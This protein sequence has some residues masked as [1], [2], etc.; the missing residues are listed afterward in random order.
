MS[1]S[2]S[3]ASP[4]CCLRAQ[5]RLVLLGLGHAPIPQRRA[6]A[7]SGG[8]GEETPAQAGRRHPEDRD[9]RDYVFRHIHPNGRIIGKPGRRQRQTYEQLGIASL[10]KPSEVIV[11]HDVVEPGK[12]RRPVAAQE[13]AQDDEETPTATSMPEQQWDQISEATEAIASIE[14]LRPENVMVDKTERQRLEKRLL[15]GYS[16]T[17][18]ER[19]LVLS[20]KQTGQTESAP[21]GNDTGGILH[22]TAWKPGHTALETRVGRIS[23]EKRRRSK[24][25]PS[26]VKQILRLAWQLSTESEAQEIGEQELYLSLLFDIN[27]NNAPVKDSLV[28]SPLLTRSSNIQPYRQDK[29]VR[30]TARKSDAAEIA[31]RLERGLARV[32]RDVLDLNVFTPLLGQAGWPATLD[33]L[34]T[35]SDIRHVS[36][37][38]KSVIE[39]DGQGTLTIYSVAETAA[40][41]MH[42]KRLLLALLDL[43]SPTLQSSLRPPDHRQREASSETYYNAVNMARWT[44]YPLINAHRRHQSRARYRAV[45]PMPKLGQSESL[46]SSGIDAVPASSRAHPKKHDLLRIPFLVGKKMADMPSFRHLAEKG[47]ERSHGADW[48]LGASPPSWKARFGVL[49]HA[50]S[51]TDPVTSPQKLVKATSTSPFGSALF[52]EQTTGLVPLL[53][54]FAPVQMVR[55]NSPSLH[56]VVVS[57]QRGS[58]DPPRRL[59]AHLTPSPFSKLG[60]EVM[61]TLPRVTMDFE[62]IDGA[63]SDRASK[64]FSRL[65][66]IH[67]TLDRQELDAAVPHLAGDLSFVR[68]QTV[69]LKEDAWQRNGRVWEVVQ[70]VQSCLA[71]AASGLPADFNVGVDLPPFMLGSAVK[72]QQEASGADVVDGMTVPYFISHYE[73]VTSVDY[74]PLRDAAQLASADAKVKRVVEHWPRGMVLRCSMVDG[75]A[76][77]GRRTAVELLPLPASEDLEEV[78]IAEMEDARVGAGVGPRRRPDQGE[79][80]L[81]KAATRVLRL[82]TL[83]HAGQLRSRNDGEEE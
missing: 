66:S 62:V 79:E 76:F 40:V 42:A 55:R 7:A 11:L 13:V 32:H 77:S 5:L 20:L 68:E 60:V 53:Q 43:P 54:H 27:R 61:R 64:V 36:Q 48:T 74:V 73:E 49:L 15:E 41:S 72:Q 57:D 1:W 50:R 24:S 22:V 12:E 65:M 29:V 10:G 37:R 81:A 31:S 83:G 80:E 26:I 39:H 3:R 59:I 9:D 17:Q 38:T 44:E 4:R 47:E 28:D 63:P 18:L 45:I 58:Q 56:P 35:E 70:K 21:S 78:A 75:G 33:Q 16:V 34:F 14:E 67:A 19:Y 52:F 51:V 82:M 30:I 8:Q 23:L 71:T 69:T 46:S 25:K 2:G 6:F